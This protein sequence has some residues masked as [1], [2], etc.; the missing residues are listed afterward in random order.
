[1]GEENQ[2][3]QATPGTQG[4][5]P[6]RV[7][8]NEDGR[9]IGATHHNARIPD[10]VVARIRDLHEA[11]GYG[12]R[13]LAKMFNLNRSTVQKICNYERR[14]QIPAGWKKATPRQQEADS[15]GEA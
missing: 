11:H 7:A 14:G 1:V 4:Q 13:R 10:A 12:Y 9:R 2:E 8:V 6:V 5:A 15:L 3:H